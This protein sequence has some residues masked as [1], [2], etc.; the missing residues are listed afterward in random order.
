[1]WLVSTSVGYV[2]CARP[3]QPGGWSAQAINLCPA[4]GVTQSPRVTVAEGLSRIRWA[5]HWGQATF[6]LSGV[7][8]GSA[9]Y[10]S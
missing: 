4:C 7:Q 6:Q 10:I 8:S 3:E 2:V 1:M 5:R 9:G